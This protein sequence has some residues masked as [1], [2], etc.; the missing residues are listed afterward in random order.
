MVQTER[1]TDLM[2]R[3]LEEISSMSETTN[4]PVLRIIKMDISGKVPLLRAE[5]VGQCVS[6]FS[7]SKSVKWITIAMLIRLEPAVETSL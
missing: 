2:N 3:R 4:S 6:I 1:V 5:C 7:V